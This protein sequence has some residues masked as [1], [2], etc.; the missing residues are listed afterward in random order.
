MSAV[1]LRGILALS[2][3]L[4]VA[5]AVGPD[6]VR[7]A[8]DAPA[9]YTAA[10][11]TNEPAPGPV[12]ADW[13]K[14]FGAPQVSMVLAQAYAGN[15]GLEQAQASLR[16]SQ[17]LLQA[18]YGIFYPQAVAD[19]AVS[20]QLATPQRTGL[21]GQAG[22]FNLFTLSASVSYALDVFGGQHRAVEALAAAAAGQRFQL[23]ATYLALSAN[24]VNTL[25]AQSAYRSE[26]EATEELVAYQRE[27]VRL[28]QVRYQ[29]GMVPYSLVL[30][31]QLQLAAAEASLPA[32]RQKLA[33]SEDLL[34]SLAGKAPAQWQAPAMRF[35]DLS[36]PARVPFSLP[37]K[38]VHQRPDILAAEQQLHA[39]SAGIGVATAAMLPSLTLSGAYGA[40]SNAANRLFSAG[41]RL[42]SVG[43][44]LTT[45]VFEGGTLWFQRKAAVEKF[46]SA[47][48]AYRQIVIAAFVQVADV[49][50]GLDND[51]LT[52]A[53]QQRGLDE[54]AAA[55]A[56]SRANDQAGLIDDSQLLDAQVQY[57]QAR[58]AWVQTRAQR[59]QD[60]VALYTALGGGWGETATLPEP[61]VPATVAAGAE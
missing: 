58:I 55:L 21:P 43:A 31:S 30:A 1:Q 10:A 35:E 32:L 40:G 33:Q 39:A 22:I 49:L 34:A 59:L 57:L 61:G 52:L 53:A 54:A 42:W 37:S 27:Q 50:H 18:G 60:T 11:G 36:E 8:V 2:A 48:A 7:P 25:I 26:V 14:Q 56:L 46:K 38:L 23:Q 29:A 47:Q 19:G 13:W 12:P 3:L 24:V 17:D 41:D 6:F 15:P 45:P 16:Q 51:A 20:R 4:S 44:D 28:A 9:R 5:C